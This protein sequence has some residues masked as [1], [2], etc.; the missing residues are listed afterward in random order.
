MQPITL[1]KYQKDAIKAAKQ[2]WGRGKQKL[3]VVMPTGT[4]KKIVFAKLI[5]EV[6]S[7]GGRVLILAHR[8]ELLK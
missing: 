2:G 1:R 4:G 6:V 7:E 5:E 8:V 3:L